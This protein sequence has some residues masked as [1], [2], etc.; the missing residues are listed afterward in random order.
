VHAYTNVLARAQDE[1]RE[2]RAEL[3]V[4]E[5]DQSL[6]DSMLSDETQEHASG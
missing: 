2:L 6:L 1:E 3:G 5:D 4:G